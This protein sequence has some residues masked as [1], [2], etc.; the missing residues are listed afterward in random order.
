MP[1][2]IGTNEV[3]G[4]EFNSKITAA[5]WLTFNT[6]FNLHYFNRKGEFQGQNFDFSGDKWQ[7]KL[8][9]KIKVAKPVDLEL[10]GN[11]ESDFKTIQGNEQQQMYMN[12][13]LR[14]KLWKGKGIINVGVRDVFASRIWRTSVDQ[15]DFYLY[16]QS[17][18]GRFMTLGFSYGFGKGEAMTYSGGR[19]H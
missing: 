3:T 4:V 15:P 8:L 6:D 9:A 1:L 11:Y 2:N 10:T 17:T 19:R 5:K 7:A 18:R 14:I 16:S 12:A 13:G